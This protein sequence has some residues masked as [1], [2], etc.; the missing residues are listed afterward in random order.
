MSTEGDSKFLSYLTGA[1]YVHPAVAAEFGSSGGTYELPCMLQ[2]CVLLGRTVI[3][4]I[5]FLLRHYELAAPKTKVSGTHV[6][7]QKFVTDSRDIVFIIYQKTLLLILLVRN[8][9]TGHT[10][11]V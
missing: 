9:S 7:R 6:S 10:C 1:R 4:W 8:R 5:E 3:Y 11:C 2:T